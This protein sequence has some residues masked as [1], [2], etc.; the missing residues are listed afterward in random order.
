[1]NYRKLTSNE[2]YGLR[3]RVRN[4]DQLAMCVLLENYLPLIYRMSAKYNRFDEAD[5][6]AHEGLLVAEKSIKEWAASTADS[7][8]LINY[9]ANGI[10]FHHLNMAAKASRKPQHF[11]IDLETEWVTR[12]SPSRELERSERSDI[13][14]KT[15]KR[16]MRRLSEEDKRL[17]KLRIWQ[18]RG[19]KEIGEMTGL[20][21]TTVWSR[22]RKLMKDLRWDLRHVRFDL[23]F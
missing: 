4:D 15:V 13:R 18:K 10:R 22:W 5:D 1:M 8:A 6:A 12:R 11:K 23:G 3:S 21:L 19:W 9:I 14:S 16:L 2:L 7:K 20:K 17:V